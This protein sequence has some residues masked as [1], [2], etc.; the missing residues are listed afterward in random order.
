MNSNESK[1]PIGSPEHHIA[2]PLDFSNALDLALA[3][4]AGQSP[5]M[6]ADLRLAIDKAVADRQTVDELRQALARQ[7]V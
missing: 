5:A 6:I 7:R 2:Q 3:A 4:S 1:P